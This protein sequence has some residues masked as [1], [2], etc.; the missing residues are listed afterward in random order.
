[1][2]QRLKEKQKTAIA[3]GLGLWQIKFIFSQF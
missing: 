2:V 3:D 1:M